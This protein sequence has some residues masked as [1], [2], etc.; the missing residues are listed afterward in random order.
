MLQKRNFPV[1]CCGYC[2]DLVRP[3]ISREVG[4]REHCPE[5]ERNH[6]IIFHAACMNHGQEN[7]TR[8]YDE[9]I[10]KQNILLMIWDLM[11]PERTAAM[12]NAVQQLEV[13]P[14]AK[15]G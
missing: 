2:N 7:A 4:W 1:L 15:L 3:L 13:Q 12:T 8:S 6:W 9:G 14:H 5:E 11:R 10:Q